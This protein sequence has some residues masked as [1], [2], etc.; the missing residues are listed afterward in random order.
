MRIALLGDVH[1]DLFALRATRGRWCAAGDDGS[2]ET[3][4]SRGQS[5][6]SKR[7]ARTPFTQRH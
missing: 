5:P 7:N 3:H 6:N 2:D 1:G 4:A